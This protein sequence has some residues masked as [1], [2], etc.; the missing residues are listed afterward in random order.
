MGVKTS[1]TAITPAVAHVAAAR[2]GARDVV[3]LQAEVK[4]KID[5]LIVALKALQADMQAG[6]A[7]ITTINTQLTALA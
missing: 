7:N 5:E 3:T 2:A 4:S 1:V 6:D